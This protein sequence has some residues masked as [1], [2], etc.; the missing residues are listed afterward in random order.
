MPFAISSID[1]KRCRQRCQGK[2]SPLKDIV[3][4]DVTAL[5]LGLETAGGVMTRRRLAE[6]A[7]GKRYRL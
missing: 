3:L 7:G 1:L 4:L 5:S 2:D 6:F